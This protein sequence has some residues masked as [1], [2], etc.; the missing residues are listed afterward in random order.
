VAAI[1]DVI[2]MQGLINLQIVDNSTYLNQAVI[3]TI[4]LF[5]MDGFQYWW[6]RAQHYFPFLWDQHVVHH[7][8][9]TIN[10]TTAVR[11]HWTE[12][13]FQAFAVALP[14][15]IIFNIKP[16]WSGSVGLVFGSF[17]FILHSN[18]KIHFGR[19]SWLV[20]SPGMHRIHHSI[21]PE[22]N[23][24]NFAAYFPIWD[25]IFGT[26]HRPKGELPPSGVAAVR[27]DTV[28]SLSTYPFVMWWRQIYAVI[29]RAA[30]RR[31]RDSLRA[32]PET[33][34]LD[35]SVSEHETG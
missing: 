27:H 33:G 19:W 2:G 28:F 31:S 11:H 10:V 12:F 29:E 8:D 16:Y 17:Q 30:D 23:D 25:V 15:S 13:M 5:F 7:S 34:R 18:L 4:F 21:L 26:Y 1:R 20:S 9:P 24:K 22:H 6:H 14:L 32:S 3:F 35:C